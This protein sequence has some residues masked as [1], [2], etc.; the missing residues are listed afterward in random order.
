MR[1]LDTNVLARWV[2]RDDEAQ[3]LAADA[4]L[5]EPCLVSITVMLELGWVLDRSLRLPRAT[6]ASMLG[7]ILQ[8]TTVTA[9][10]LA[11]LTWALERYRAGAD[12]ADAVHLAD[13][14][15]LATAFVTFDRGLVR[16]LREHASIDVALIEV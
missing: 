2:L 9:E 14:T 5:R 3:A 13:T 7:Q 16:K 6:V 11:G 8:L 12:W 15:G 1:A 4:I 10:N